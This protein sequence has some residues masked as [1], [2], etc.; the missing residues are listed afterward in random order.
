MDCKRS[1]KIFN[2]EEQKNE[3]DSKIDIETFG[4][5]KKNYIV[6]NEIKFKKKNENFTIYDWS[7]KIKLID[8]IAYKKKF[9]FSETKIGNYEINGDVITVIF[10]GL[11]R[12]FLI[13]DDKMYE[14]YYEKEF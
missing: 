13:E 4:G 9:L 11:K 1:K 12:K 2:G 5:I 8:H 14:I 3:F 10:D 6:S 7:A